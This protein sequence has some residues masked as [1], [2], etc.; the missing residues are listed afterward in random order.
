MTIAK[1][2]ELAK[3][4]QR[5]PVDEPD[6]STMK[7]IFS[8]LDALP[9][10]DAQLAEARAECDIAKTALEKAQA[11]LGLPTPTNH[12]ETPLRQKLAV[13][14]SMERALAA[15]AAMLREIGVE[16][17]N[18]GIECLGRPGSCDDSDPCA[19]CRLCSALSTPS[20]AA[21]W[22]ATVRHE[23]DKEW[24]S[25]LGVE[26]PVINAHLPDY[27]AAHDDRVRRETL[28][29]AAKAAE[30]STDGLWQEEIGRCRAGRVRATDAIRSL[31]PRAPET[32]PATEVKP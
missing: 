18:E 7:D 31:S 17:Q 14:E 21:E 13:A 2:K 22:L 10:Y 12:D 23:R 6:R 5:L 28:E 29:E 4:L 3:R 9:D 20:R 30:N 19:F 11:E 1:L 16:L 26:P 32:A 8:A 25:A 15:E 24:C 27:V